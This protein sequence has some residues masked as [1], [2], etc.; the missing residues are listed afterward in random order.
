MESWLATDGRESVALNEISEALVGLAGE[1]A[2][3]DLSSMLL[4]LPKSA[5]LGWREMERYLD[6]LFLYQGD[7]IYTSPEAIDKIVVLFK[8]RGI[9]PV[10]IVDYLQRVPPPPERAA[11]EQAHHIDYVVRSLKALAMRRGVPVLAVGAVD[12]EAIRRRG[13]VHLEDLWGPVTMTYEPDGGWVLNHDG[14]GSVRDDGRPRRVRL[15]IEKNRQ[16][17][18]EVEWRH[19]LYGGAFHLNPGGRLVPPEQSYQSERV[20]AT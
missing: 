11:L 1:G 13:P 14:P 16:G 12:E 20:A 18:S 17:P 7:P 19:N 9:F 5:L 2:L 15:A 8:R 6:T 4:E 10:V 3:E